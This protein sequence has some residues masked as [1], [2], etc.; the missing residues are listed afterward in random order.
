ML[1]CVTAL[2]IEALPLPETCYMPCA[3]RFAESHNT[4]TRQ[5]TSLPS[6]WSPTLRQTRSTHH[7]PYLLSAGAPQTNGTRQNMDMPSAS[8]RAHGKAGARASHARRPSRPFALPSASRLAL[9]KMR[10]CRVSFP[11]TRQSPVLPKKKFCGRRGN[12]ARD[13]PHTKNPPLPS[14]R[15]LFS[16]QLGLRFLKLYI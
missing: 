14:R 6:A 2:F 13:L 8:E 1:H 3:R 7:N 10:F 11:G 4:G 9:G 16:V 5:R 15:S 12:R